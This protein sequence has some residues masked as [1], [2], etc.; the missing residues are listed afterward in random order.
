MNSLRPSFTERDAFRDAVAQAYAEGR[1]DDDAFARRQE[2]LERAVTIG[3]L[4][5]AVDDL[6]S[7]YIEVAT[8]SSDHPVPLTAHRPRWGRRVFLGIGAA[9]VG[10][11]LAGGIGAARGL[12]PSI[13]S[14][15]LPSLGGV[16]TFAVGGLAEPF[17]WLEKHEYVTYTDVTLHGDA[18]YA[19]ALVPGRKT[20]VD[21]INM[22][23]SDAPS[24]RPYGL[25]SAGAQTFTLDQVTW[26]RIPEMARV[27]PDVLGSRGKVTHI[28]IEPNQAH[29]AAIRAYVDGDAYGAGG[30]IVEW[31]P[32]GSAI[33]RRDVD[34]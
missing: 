27:A 5:E 32:D 6:P 3:D 4:E 15:S 24:T 30:G 7:S 10:F 19:R 22:I 28:I 31:T 21:Y 9:A 20:A 17:A 25:L 8:R 18:F 33:L 12:L 11:G 34:E 23:R 26:D 2:Q 16:D 13:Q 29:G 14:L 1:L